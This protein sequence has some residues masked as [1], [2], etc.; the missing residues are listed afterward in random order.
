MSRRLP[1][2]LVIEKNQLGGAKTIRTAVVRTTSTTIEQP[3]PLDIAIMKVVDARS[4]LL[5]L[6]ATTTSVDAFC[7]TAM[8]PTQPTVAL[9][10]STTVQGTHL[11]VVAVMVSCQE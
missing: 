10:M 6:A 4:I 1:S 8:K 11:F 9:S 2:S 5:A 7:P 3:Y